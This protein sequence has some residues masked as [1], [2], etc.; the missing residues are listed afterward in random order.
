M[1]ISKEE[2]KE[3]RNALKKEFPNVKF[4]VKKNHKGSSGIV[5]NLSLI[6]I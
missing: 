6:H 4:Q 3:I 1:Y 2:I 5:V